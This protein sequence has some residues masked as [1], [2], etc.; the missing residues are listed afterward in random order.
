MVVYSRQSTIL[1]AHLHFFKEKII[2]LRRTS[3]KFRR[4][5]ALFAFDSILNIFGFWILS[6]EKKT[7]TKKEVTLGLENCLP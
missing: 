7:R 4:F 2:I 3:F 6:Q 5:P 1:I